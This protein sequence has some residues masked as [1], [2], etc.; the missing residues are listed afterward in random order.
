[1]TDE[2]EPRKRSGPNFAHGL[3]AAVGA[4]IVATFGLSLGIVLMAGDGAAM[5]GLTVNDMG[6]VELTGAAAVGVASAV[7][8][9]VMGLLGLI[10]AAAA[11]LISLAAGAAGI[12]GA[13]IIGVGVL[14]GPLLLVGMIVVFIKRRFYPDII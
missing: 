11:T 8:S 5:P 10:T 12:V 13:V 9:L 7:M 2:P 4:F 3:G 14:T 1:M 6:M